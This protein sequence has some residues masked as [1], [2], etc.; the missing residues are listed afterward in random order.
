MLASVVMILAFTLACGGGT[1]ATTSTPPPTTTSTALPGTPVT[2]DGGTYQAITPA[3][4]YS[5]LQNKDFFMADTDTEYIGEIAGTDAFINFNNINQ[6][7]G[8]FPADK[9]SKIVV[10]CMSGIKSQ[11]TAA[12]LVKA[13]YTRV[14]ELKGG[15]VA[16]NQQ[17]YPMVNK[18]RTMT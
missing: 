1:P 6:E 15:V 9:T 10:Y 18:T 14:M 4:L 5:M 2:V 11:T 16:W 7:L 8:K 3:Q 12:L 17:G 13:G